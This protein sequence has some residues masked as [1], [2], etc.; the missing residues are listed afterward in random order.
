MPTLLWEQPRPFR[1]STNQLKTRSSSRGKGYTKVP[2]LEPLKLLW[3]VEKVLQ[4]Y[5]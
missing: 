1:F 3:L 2:T 5:F 4:R